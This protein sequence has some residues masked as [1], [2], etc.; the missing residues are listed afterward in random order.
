MNT[1]TVDF[2]ET[3]AKYAHYYNQESILKEQLREIVQERKK[4]EKCIHANMR[5]NNLDEISVPGAN[6][7][8]MLKEK[9]TNKRA[10]KRD[11]A[12]FLSEQ[13]G[14]SAED[15]AKTLDSLKTETT[16][17]KMKVIRTR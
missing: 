8:I 3:L 10:S 9:V 1:T 2:S 4:H 14:V 13:L 17:K 11:I 7:M 15:V 16:I 6:I 5:A 12:S